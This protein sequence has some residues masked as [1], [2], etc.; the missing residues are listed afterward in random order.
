MTESPAEPTNPADEEEVVVEVR[1]GVSAC[2][3]GQNVRY[4]GGHKRSRFLTDEL[5]QLVELVGVCPEVE[6]GMSTPRET[7]ADVTALCTID[8][9]SALV[10]LAP[11][12]GL[13]HLA[14]WHAAVS[15]RPSASA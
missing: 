1:V 9:A 4:D 7:I 3:L 12:P 5:A 6:V 14:R 15:A 11:D 2:L 13:A 10:N 8:F